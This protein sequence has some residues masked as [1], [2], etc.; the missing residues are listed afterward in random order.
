[1]WKNPVVLFIVFIQTFARP[2][3]S[4]Q[5]NSTC[6]YCLHAA[7]LGGENLAILNCLEIFFL[8]HV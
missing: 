3:H 4:G 8:L 7:R 1:M 6:T 2:L 5:H